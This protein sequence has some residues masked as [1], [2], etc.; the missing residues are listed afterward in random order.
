MTPPAAPDEDTPTEAQPGDGAG[1][2]SSPASDGGR[3]VPVPG[4]AIKYHFDGTRV[5][6]WFDYAR[7]AWV[8]L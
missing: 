6:R 5:A 7:E 4:P 1:G 2:R 8:P 3:F